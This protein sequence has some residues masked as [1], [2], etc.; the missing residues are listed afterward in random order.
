MKAILVDSPYLESNNDSEEHLKQRIE[1]LSRE[2]KDFYKKFLADWIGKDQEDLVKEIL[3]SNPIYTL[4]YFFFSSYR[5]SD[6]ELETNKI[7]TETKLM[8]LKQKQNVLFNLVQPP[9]Q[10]G[11]VF[12]HEGRKVQLV[13]DQEEEALVFQEKHLP[14][15][16]LFLGDEMQMDDF[17]DIDATNPHKFQF[18]ED[19][20]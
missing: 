15:M 5:F 20:D 17:D 9:V 4:V 13:Y 3:N 16:D 12:K 19:I 8:D 11:D 2:G 10:I 18:L 6:S 14:Q 7:S 1:N